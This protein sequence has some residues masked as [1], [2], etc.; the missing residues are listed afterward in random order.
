MGMDLYGKKFKHNCYLSYNFSGWTQLIQYLNKW[1]VD[2][3]EFSGFNDGNLIK[4]KTCQAVA[5]AI[6]ANWS[7]VKQKDKAWLR[8]HPYRW[9][10]LAEENGAKQW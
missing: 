1:G 10:K 9:R 6:D 8:G 5:D 2:T 4:A 7:R 3:S